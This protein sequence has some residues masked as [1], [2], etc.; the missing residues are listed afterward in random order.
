MIFGD[1]EIKATHFSLTSDNSSSI[2]VALKDSDNVL[3]LEPEYFLSYMT[4]SE[5]EVYIAGYIQAFNDRNKGRVI[6]PSFILDGSAGELIRRLTEQQNV[7]SVS[8]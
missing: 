8:G 7:V 2:S 3:F 6:F 5:Q 4:P 1:F